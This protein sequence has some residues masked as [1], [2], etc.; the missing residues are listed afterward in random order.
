MLVRTD[1]DRHRIAYLSIP[2][3]LRVEIPGHGT[4]KINS[5]VP[6]GGPAL[7]ITTIRALTKLPIHHLV[8][9][10]FAGFRK[11][12]D[13]LGGIDV[14]VPGPIVSNRFDCPYK[15][16]ARCQS[17]RGW[18]FAK[19]RQH[20]DGRRA[21]VYSRIRENR[22][23]A[24]ENDLT[25]A[26]RQQQVLQAMMGKLTSVRTLARL[27][28]IGDALLAPLA[29]DLTAGQFLQLGWVKFRAPNDRVLHCRLGGSP[30]TIGGES[31][32]IAEQE[33]FAVI[34][35]FT[36]RSAP[37]PPPPGSGAYGAGCTLGSAVR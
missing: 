33:N 6:L 4:G 18:R 26:D 15:T 34:A 35:M 16:A 21:L 5:A 22:L 3:D 37:Q 9:V 24:S 20:M 30:Q 36:G 17:W 13:E 14:N 29:S 23:N 25:R 27:P 28:W 7:A 1:P 31:F 32:V 10:N 12:I 8:V 11:L 2:R 19:G